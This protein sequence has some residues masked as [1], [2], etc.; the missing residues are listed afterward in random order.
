MAAQ[1]LRMET[2]SPMA[3]RELIF[4]M[5]KASGSQQLFHR[6]N[7]PKF[8][9]PNGKLFVMASTPSDSRGY[10]NALSLL[11]RELQTTHPV[12][13][14]MGRNLSHKDKTSLQLESL[15]LLNSLSTSAL[16]AGGTLPQVEAHILEDWVKVQ[17][18]PATLPEPTPISAE[19]IFT[20][21]R[22]ARRPHELKPPPAPVRTLSDDQ[23]KAANLVLREAGPA[24]M[25]AFLADVRSGLVEVTPALIAARWPE[26]LTNPKNLVPSTRSMTEEDFMDNMLERACAELIATTDRIANHGEELIALKAKQDAEVLRQ[27]QLEIYIRK[28]E[29]LANEAAALLQDI[30]P[31]VP[32]EKPTPTPVAPKMRRGRGRSGL[33]FGIREIRAKVYPILRALGYDWNTD[34]VMQEIEKLNLGGDG[35]FGDRNQILGWLHG[36]T[37]KG[38]PLA[39]TTRGRYDFADL[40]KA[41]AQAQGDAAVAALNTEPSNNS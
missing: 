33:K 9:L 36:D 41:R 38:G 25:N 29:D 26:S 27:T 20:P 18:A 34:D 5:L 37:F 19:P 15:H 2:L 24:A 22:P 21:Y 17:E 12:V 30:L 8:K 31:P 3:Q 13:A 16:V 1:T 28:H 14:E 35:N 39:H 4:E 32:A 23:L 7:H 11:R 10:D 6:K 40:V